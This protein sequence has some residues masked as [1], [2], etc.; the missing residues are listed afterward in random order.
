[1]LIVKGE[2]NPWIGLVIYHCHWDLMRQEKTETLKDDRH[3]RESEQSIKDAKRV[4]AA[5]LSGNERQTTLKSKRKQS[6]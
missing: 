5:W 2:K 6:N 3:G 4:L 1:M